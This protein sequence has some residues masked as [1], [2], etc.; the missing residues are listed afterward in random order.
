[1]A[2]GDLLAMSALVGVI[3][4]AIAMA[5]LYLDLRAE[6]HR[7]GV[8]ATRLG[9]DRKQVAEIERIAKSQTKQADQ[10]QKLVETLTKIV[11]SYEAEVG[12]LR[13]EVESLRGA[14]GSA[15][16]AS[17]GLVEVEKQK[18]AQR[19]RDAEWRKTRD[20]AKGLGWLLDR[21]SSDDEEEDE[22]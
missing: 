16:V 13:R 11:A 15:K 3:G 20:L 4:L 8:E 21:M 12:P 18:L 10:V 6:R 5:K 14:T 22:K 9:L 7:S 17:E 1:M 2:N 19:Q